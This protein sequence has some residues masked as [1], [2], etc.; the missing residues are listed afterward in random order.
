MQR[1]L[2][3]ESALSATRLEFVSVATMVSSYEDHGASRQLHHVGMIYK[4]THLMQRVDLLVKEE[5]LWMELEGLDFEELTPFG[6]DAI[7]HLPN[8]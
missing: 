4:V 7:D 8:D 5:N 6:K 3:E 1:E 2:S